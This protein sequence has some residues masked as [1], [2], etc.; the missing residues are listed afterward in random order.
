MAIRADEK[1]ANIELGDKS[2]TIHPT[3]VVES[4]AKIAQGVKIGPY[5]VIGK[6]VELKEGVVLQAHVVVQG[7]T[8]LKENVMVYPFATVGIASND[9]KYLPVE[10]T[11]TVVGKGTI[12]REYA[13]IH[14]GT[15]KPTEETGSGTVVGERCVIMQ[16]AHVGHDCK[17]GNGV[18]MSPY[19]GLS[20]EVIV[21]DN[22]IMG[23]KS[24]VHQFCTIGKGAM[25]G[26]MAKV[27]GDI[28]P[29]TLS[30]GAPAV[31]RAVNVIG[32]QRRGVSEEEVKIVRDFYKKLFLNK[33]EL[34]KDKFEFVKQKYGKYSKCADIISFIENDCRR[35]LVKH[36]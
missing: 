32:L 35:Q 27:T 1:L 11:T 16:Y 7:K 33:N 9:L 8:I 29:Y 12:I 22:A 21:H 30:D 13:N 20:G 2:T 10:A 28:A 26:G 14:A 4:G 25:V 34:W 23:A 18:L 19:V 5:C 24:G 31:L 15:P 3:A 36:K 17:I 6:D